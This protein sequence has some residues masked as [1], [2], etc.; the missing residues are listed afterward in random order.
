MEVYFPRDTGQC[1]ENLVN[2]PNKGQ[3]KGKLEKDCE[4]QDKDLS[5]FT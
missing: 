5:I 4:F 2:R 1:P 3:V